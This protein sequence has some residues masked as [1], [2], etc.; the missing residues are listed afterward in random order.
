MGFSPFGRLQGSLV[1]GLLERV[2]GA[3]IKSPLDRDYGETSESDIQISTAEIEIAMAIAQVYEPLIQL[4]SEIEGLSP[5]HV[6]KIGR[7]LHELPV[8]KVAVYR[9]QVDGDAGRVELQLRMTK[10]SG[11]EA[12][13]HFGGSEYVIGKVSKVFGTGDGGGES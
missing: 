12:G 5:E 1:G 2:A 10:L 13:L 3:F 8:G 11:G 9:Y 6:K 4:Y 7:R